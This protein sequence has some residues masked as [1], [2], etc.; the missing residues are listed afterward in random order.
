MNDRLFDYSV[1][2]IC[3]DHLIQEIASVS[4]AQ[5]FL[6]GWPQEMRG[7]I[8][9]TAIQACDYA[10]DG[11]LPSSSARAC[12][13]SFARSARILD[14]IATLRDLGGQGAEAA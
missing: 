13:A 7:S 12:F 2:V 5:R 6:E 1:F 10:S 11:R 3:G 9:R 14:D 4:E 8:H